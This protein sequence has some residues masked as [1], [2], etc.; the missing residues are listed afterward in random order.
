MIKHL[1]VIFVLCAAAIA[2]AQNGPT[3]EWTKTYGQSGDDWAQT[4]LMV[5]DGYII[6][7]STESMGF[8]HSDFLLIKTD[9][10]GNTLW[11]RTYGSADVEVLGEAALTSDS[12]F[13]LAGF[14]GKFGD[15]LLTHAY[16]VRTDSKGDT[17]WTRVLERDSGTVVEDVISLSDGGFALTGRAN[18]FGQGH[19][20]YL[21]KTDAKG[22]LLWTK[23]FGGKAWD[24][25]EA[26]QE[27]KDGGF[28]VAGRTA[29]YGEGMFDV[30]VVRTNASGDT[31]WTRTV[32]G[33]KNERAYDLV[34]TASGD[35]VIAGETESFT[36]GG[37]DVYLIRMTANGDTV[38]T[39]AV[40]G[41]KDEAAKAVTMTAD[42]GIAV[43]GYT[44]SFGAGDA[45][46]YLVKADGTGNV[47]WTQAYG[48][49]E[50]DAA[51]SLQELPDHGYILAGA[52]RSSGKG[53]LDFYVVR[54]KP[55]PV[56][57]AD[58]P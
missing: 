28:V 43:A 35:L 58:K 39:R 16:L 29:S 47:R 13:I 18:T 38:W 40:G 22:N 7:G 25:G 1:S 4:V 36:H 33:H 3:A 23:N 24:D 55:F 52:T 50:W 6:A 10:A 17:L 15:S 5:R 2:A 45:D 30:Y 37:R 20:M 41:A 57:A 46:M 34:Q 49:P 27:T 53:A 54:T 42:S 8:G 56:S 26:V 51:E 12:G 44:F 14:T 9:A 19:N 48:G 21:W 11:S 31:L 32:G